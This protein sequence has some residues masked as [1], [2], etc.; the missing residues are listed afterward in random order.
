[1]L[2]YA[3]PHLKAND[4]LE[5]TNLKKLVIKQTV[6]GII[7]SAGEDTPL[8]GVSVFIKGTSTGTVTDLDGRYSIEVDEGDILI[9]S[10][11]GYI[12]QEIPARTRKSGHRICLSGISIFFIDPICISC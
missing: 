8:I 12:S 10:Y 6:T 11:T 1:M 2:F 3:S 5:T 4:L 9:F 7:T